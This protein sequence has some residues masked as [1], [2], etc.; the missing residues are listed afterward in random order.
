VEDGI[1]PTVAE[2]EE[3]GLGTSGF[4]AENNKPKT[5]VKNLW[6]LCHCAMGTDQFV[7]GGS[8]HR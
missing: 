2:A 6:M 3:P 8:Q 5:K 7:V 4:A 1:V